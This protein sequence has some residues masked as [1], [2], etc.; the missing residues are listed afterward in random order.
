MNTPRL[1]T[2]RLILRKF[3]ETDI[4][5]IFEIYRDVEVKRF[6]PWLPVKT[7]AGAAQ[8]FQEQYAAHYNRRYGYDYAICL[9][10]DDR[11]IGYMKVSMDSSYDLGYG[12]GQA[13][14]HQGIATEA[15]KAV[16]AQVRKQYSYEEQWQPKDLLVTF[17]LYQMN[18]D[19]NTD[20]VFQKYWDRSEVHLIGSA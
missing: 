16:I 7:M 8:I 10:K 1:E 14:W 11:P 2:E 17:R 5:W 18:L 13:Y 4:P 20:R 12:L 3:T 9:K 19:G 6:L 15:G